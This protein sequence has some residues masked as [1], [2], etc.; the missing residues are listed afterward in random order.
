MFKAMCDHIRYS[1]HDGAI[2]PTITIFRKRQEGKSDFRVWNNLMVSFAG[3][4]T[5]S[6]RE[7]NF[8]GD[9]GIVNKIGDQ[10][11]LSF[12]RVSIMHQG[13]VKYYIH[14]FNVIS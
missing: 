6:S 13:V 5:A 3:Y 1:Y 10:Q 11:N 7:A 8:P 9:E 14:R 4:I 12:T 2:R